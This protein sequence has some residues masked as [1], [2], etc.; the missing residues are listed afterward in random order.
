LAQKGRVADPLSFLKKVDEEEL[1][2]EEKRTAI[3]RST[4]EL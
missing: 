2:N 4:A 3:F 1:Q